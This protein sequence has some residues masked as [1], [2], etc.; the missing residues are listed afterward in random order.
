M[1]QI[2]A[3]CNRA[4]WLK[5][6]RIALA[7]PPATVVS[8]YNDYLAGLNPNHTAVAAPVTAT[9]AAAAVAPVHRGTARID[10]ITV[11]ADGVGGRELPV[12]S[13]NTTVSIRVDFLSD[14][15]LPAPSVGIC[16]VHGNGMTVAS[17]GSHNDGVTLSRHANG[18]GAA[19]LVLP[20]LP[21]LKGD[22]TVDVYLMCERG[23]HVYEQALQAARLQ[24]TQ[25]GLELGLVTLPHRWEAD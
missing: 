21:L 19:T 1:Y 5:E 16:L 24:V 20:A 12:C 23:I 18:R 3:I 17:A 7:G 13:Q 14:P 25:T 8:A 2:E 4:I 10:G 9:P 11:S 15:D 22:Y 6:G